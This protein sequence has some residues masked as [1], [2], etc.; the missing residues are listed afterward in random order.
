MTSRARNVRRNYIEGVMSGAIE[1]PKAGTAE[2]NSL[3]KLASL[4]RW[5]K[6]PKEGMRPRGRTTGIMP[7]TNEYV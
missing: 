1:A 5:G 6:V 7:K 4:E 3:A 2:A